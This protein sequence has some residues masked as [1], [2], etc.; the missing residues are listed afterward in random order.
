VVYL[1]SVFSA[2]IAVLFMVVFI[3]KAKVRNYTF[4]IEIYV[5]PLFFVIINLSF[6]FCGIFR[7][8]RILALSF[9]N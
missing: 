5:S 8:V 9:K 3:K 6:S 7:L 1:L 4:I 2:L